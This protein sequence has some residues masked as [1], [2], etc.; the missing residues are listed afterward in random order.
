MINSMASVAQFLGIPRGGPKPPGKSAIRR[1]GGRAK[2]KAPMN[3]QQHMN[4]LQGHMK[5]GN[6]A[7]AKTSALMLAKALHQKSLGA[8]GGTTV[9]PTPNAPPASA[10]APDPDM[11][12]Y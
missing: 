7:G 6:T 5:S 3:P 4:A 2:P 1:G 10:T 8:Q 11:M 12:S 9:N